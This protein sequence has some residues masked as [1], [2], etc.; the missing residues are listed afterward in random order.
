[1][2]KI[3]NQ[4]LHHTTTLSLFLIKDIK[5]YSIFFIYTCLFGP[6]YQNLQQQLITSKYNNALFTINS[7][8]NSIYLNECLEGNNI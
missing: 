7:L 5:P 6:N 4:L 1:M 8:S 3:K 2:E